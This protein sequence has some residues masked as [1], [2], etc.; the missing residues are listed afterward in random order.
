MTIFNLSHHKDEYDN[1]EEWNF[2]GTNACD[3]TG[4]TVK[5]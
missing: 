5:D 1:N 4:R 2:F 3:V